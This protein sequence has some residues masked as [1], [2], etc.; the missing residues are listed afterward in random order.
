MSAEEFLAEI[1]QML[2]MTSDVARLW[3]IYERRKD[4]RDPE[5]T[6]MRNATFRLTRGHNG[7][8]V[9]SLSVLGKRDADHDLEL[10]F[11]CFAKDFQRR[12]FRVR[13]EGK[14]ITN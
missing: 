3:V 4:R 14:A 6:E 12:N 2:R 5:T 7:V 8:I 13:Y 9:A 10:V 1:R 11:V